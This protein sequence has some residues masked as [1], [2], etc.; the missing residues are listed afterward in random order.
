VS[1]W[2]LVRAPHTSIPLRQG[3][4]H[5]SFPSERGKRNG[6]AY[7][8][9]KLLGRPF[10]LKAFVEKGVFDGNLKERGLS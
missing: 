5:T 10:L 8:R 3:Q 7:C 9:M 6:G 2:L 4:P 1:F